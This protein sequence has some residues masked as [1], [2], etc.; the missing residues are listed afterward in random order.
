MTEISSGVQPEKKRKKGA[1]AA[2]VTLAI[3][4]TAAAVLAVLYFTGILEPLMV[5]AAQTFQ[6]L[7][8]GQA[9][10]LEQENPPEPWDPDAEDTAPGE[11]AD[12]SG[13]A[14][15]TVSDGKNAADGPDAD[16]T[17]A[18][19]TAPPD[20]AAESEPDVP[21]DDQQQE[22]ERDTCILPTDTQLISAQQLEGMDREQTYMV[23]N[24]IYARHG[25]IFITDSIQA[26]FEGKSWYTPYSVDSNDIVPLFTEIEN[27]NLAVVV[28]YQRAMGYRK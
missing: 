21:E 5:R 12:G 19:Q 14:D 6:T 27:R 24:E 7:L 1:K 26:Y 17:G 15:Q 4:L 23:I 10:M 8:P 2:L 13:P 9:D 11:D 18:E 22:N 20:D 25:K 28:E 3:L 16:N